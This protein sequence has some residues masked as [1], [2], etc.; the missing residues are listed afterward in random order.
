[1]QKLLSAK[2]LLLDTKQAVKGIWKLCISIL[3]DSNLGPRGRL[4]TES[5]SSSGLVL[6]TCV[7]WSLYIFLPLSA[8]AILETE[9]ENYEFLI[10]GQKKSQQEKQKIGSLP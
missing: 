1:M 8:A 6:S 2:I 3:R 9:L 7:I 5:P 10:F 4:H